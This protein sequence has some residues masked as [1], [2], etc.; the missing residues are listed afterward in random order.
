MNENNKPSF[1]DK[2]KSSL[3]YIKE[4][5]IKFPLYILSHPLKGFDIFKREK[6]AKTSVAIVFVILLILLNILWIQYAGFEVNDFEIKDLNSIS[7]IIYI[8]GIVGLLTISNW[9]VTTLFD[10]KGKMKDIFLMICYSLYPM[11]WANAIGIILSQ[12]LTG[13]ELAVYSLVMALGTFLTCYMIFMGM[14]S[15]HEYGLGKCLLTIL[16]T[17]I[18]AAIIVFI[19][20]L[21]YNLFQT[22]YGFFYTIY[23]EIT[24]R[25]I[26]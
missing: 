19:L 10:G 2:V 9:S 25:N 3:V 24:L 7:E 12:I 26:I 15:I 1:M 23:Q 18:A 16:F 5:Y 17:I 11:I 13:E 21:S 6:R 22:I 14:I 8:V 4:E 20:L